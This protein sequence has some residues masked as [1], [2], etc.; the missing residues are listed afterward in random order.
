MHGQGVQ[1]SEVE[2]GKGHNEFGGFSLARILEYISGRVSGDSARLKEAGDR[3]DLGWV[4]A[5]ES[6]GNR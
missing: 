1:R 6:G 5:F 2:V 3:E 4:V